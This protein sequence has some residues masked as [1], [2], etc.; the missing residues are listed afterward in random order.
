MLLISVVIAVVSIAVCSK[1]IEEIS[2]IVSA[3]F[4]ASNA[5]FAVSLLPAILP[6]SVS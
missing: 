1:S 2:S 5:L 4:D 6:V 3:S